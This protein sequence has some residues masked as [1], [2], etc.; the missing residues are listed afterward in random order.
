MLAGSRG[1]PVSPAAAPSHAGASEAEGLTGC[2]RKNPNPQGI[3][4]WI[5]DESSQS[6]FQSSLITPT[7][8]V[9]PASASGTSHTPVPSKNVARSCPS[10]SRPQ[11]QLRGRDW[12]GTSL[13]LVPHPFLLMLAS[14]TAPPQCL[15]P[16]LV[17][18]TLGPEARGSPGVRT[19]SSLYLGCVSTL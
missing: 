14:V 2:K 19:H 3:W 4:F 17:P 13:H 15:L 16:H 1:N 7:G 18:L 12:L 8:P 10:G 5:D 11:G 6:S 9:S